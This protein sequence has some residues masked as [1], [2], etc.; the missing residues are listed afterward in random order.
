MFAKAHIFFVSNQ[1]A[2]GM[3]LKWSRSSA[4]CQATSNTK[5]ANAKNFGWAVSKK[6]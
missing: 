6:P 1:F 4:T 2:K 5:S 3:T